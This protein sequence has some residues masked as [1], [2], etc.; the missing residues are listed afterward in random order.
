MSVFFNF[1]K[2]QFEKNT[3]IFYAS[4]NNRW[5]RL[6]VRY[7]V[8]EGALWGVFVI[9][10]L[11]GGGQMLYNCQFWG[12]IFISY[13]QNSAI[14]DD[15][16]AEMRAR[17]DALV[18]ERERLLEGLNR[19]GQCQIRPPQRRVA[20]PPPPLDLAR[21]RQPPV[22]ADAM[23]V[24]DVSLGGLNSLDAD[25]VPLRRAR[26][27]EPR[28]DA[29]AGSPAGSEPQGERDPLG[30]R[31]GA[32]TLVLSGRPPRPIG[33]FASGSRSGLGEAIHVRL[34]PALSALSERAPAERDAA[35]PVSIA[36]LV[37]GPEGCGGD[38]CGFA[39]VWHRQLPVARVHAIARAA[40]DATCGFLRE[41]GAA[42]LTAT[43]T[44]RLV[45]DL[46]RVSGRFMDAR[47]QVAE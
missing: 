25:P 30:R 17:Y 6:C 33:Q 21:T 41:T 37:D 35:R 3:L 12:I 10:L 8:I 14:S 44:E 47:C 18:V 26:A 24:D 11:I 13:C 42:F 27:L 40:A 36:R 29:G 38:S 9:L 2:L 19:A 22:A 16:L 7:N 4:V 1:Y 46:P 31:F 5:W 15:G 23:L 34:E 43:E 45:F 28:L 20:V 39:P 32:H